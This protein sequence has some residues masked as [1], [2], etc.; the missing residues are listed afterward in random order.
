MAHN[1]QDPK[2]MKDSRST[3]L[4]LMHEK[5]TMKGFVLP[6][7]ARPKDGRRVPRFVV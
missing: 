2:G 3:R 7:S 6:I 4:I 1:L 5:R